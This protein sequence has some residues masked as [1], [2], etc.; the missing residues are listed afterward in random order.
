MAKRSGEK[1]AATTGHQG[2]SIS[3]AIRRGDMVH[4]RDL[5]PEDTGRVTSIMAAGGT[6]IIKARFYGGKVYTYPARYFALASA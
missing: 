3:R 4:F 2:L 6:A 1:A 5:D